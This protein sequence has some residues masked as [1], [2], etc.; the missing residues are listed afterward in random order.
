MEE[1]AHRLLGYL[2]KVLGGLD[3]TALS[4]PLA[5]CTPPAACVVVWLIFPDK[6]SAHNALAGKY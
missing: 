1:G 4:S 3:Q 2:A 6:G 5:P